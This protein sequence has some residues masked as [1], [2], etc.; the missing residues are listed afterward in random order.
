MR[1]GGATVVQDTALNQPNFLQN[2]GHS[3]HTVD[4]MASSLRSDPVPVNLQRATFRLTFSPTYVVVGVYRL[5]TDK[6]LY[7]PAWDKCKH[8]VRRGL[9]VGFVWVCLG[10]RLHGVYLD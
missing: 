1:N 3:N 10:I 5:S 8:G 9:I 2:R 6:S 4:A 7:K